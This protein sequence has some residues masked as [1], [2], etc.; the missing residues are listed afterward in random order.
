MRLRVLPAFGSVR[1][2]DLDR[3]DLQRFVHALLEEGHEPSTIDVTLLPLRAGYRQALERG[4][5]AVNPCDRLSMPRANSRRERIAD[6]AEAAALLAVLPPGTSRC[7]RSPCTRAYGAAS[8]RP[9]A[10]A[11]LTWRPG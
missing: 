7:G 9:Y 5:V 8:C 4:E 3:I 1:L 11:T 6:P 10:P 2:A